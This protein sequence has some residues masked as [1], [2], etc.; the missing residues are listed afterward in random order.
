M[1]FAE[2]QHCYRAM[3]EFADEYAGIPCGMD[4]ENL[5]VHP[6]YKFAPVFNKEPDES[7]DYT[8]INQW[9]SR[10][11]KASCVIMREKDGRITHLTIKDDPIGRLLRTFGLN[12]V[13]SLEAEAKAQQKLAELIKHHHF[14]GYLLTGCFIET[15]KR[16]GI[17]YILRRLRPTIALRGSPD[18]VRFLASLCLHP[19]GYYDESFAGSMVPTDE[20][21]AHLVLMRGDEHAFW[22][23]SN[24]HQEAFL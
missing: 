4:G 16:S 10:R 13:W 2:A 22:K 19:I 5:I 6:S 7:A 3:A 12:P 1:T 11:L 23:W 17:T 18:G 24:Q 8:V 21:I 20:V 15:S 9:H 14:R